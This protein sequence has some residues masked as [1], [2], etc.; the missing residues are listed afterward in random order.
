MVIGLRAKII[1]LALLILLA[2][3]VAVWTYDRRIDEE[4]VGDTRRTALALAEALQVSVQQLGPSAEP[5][6]ALL[7]DYARRLGPVGVKQITLL[8]G[9]KEPLAGSQGQGQGPG[10]HM[11]LIEEQSRE[12]GSPSTWD[13]LVPI[14]VGADKL[15]YVQLK[16]TSA[17]F[18][19][20]LAAVRLERSTVTFAAFTLG[21]ILAVFLARRVTRPMEELRVAAQTIAAGGLE[22]KLPEV[23]LPE[24]TGRDEIGALVTAFREMLNGLKERDLL[25]AKL[26][27]AEREAQIGQLAARIAHDVRNPLNYLSL[28][29]DHVLA[30]VEGPELTKIGAQMKSELRRADDRIAELLSLGRPVTITPMELELRPLIESLATN[31]S[32]ALHP[33]TVHGA[34]PGIVSWDASVVEE[35]LRNLLTNARQAMSGGGPIAITLEVVAEQIAIHVDDRGAGFEENV[36]AH[37]FEPWFTTKSEG[38][39]LGLMLARKAARQHGGD[40]RAANR[41]DGGARLSLILP[42][43][44]GRNT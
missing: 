16:M 29:L 34:E 3:L 24:K 32:T 25:R 26:E 27:A 10:Q 23:K 5:D 28:G 6:E 35:I 21:L 18:E 40:L 4:M 12:D 30:T 33:I 13:L 37:L 14:V 11:F 22:V 7:R 38:V 17:D 15:G 31:T 20:R 1:G 41:E 43:R 9:D 36:K 44:F 8:S 42:R 2:V 19:D 39:G